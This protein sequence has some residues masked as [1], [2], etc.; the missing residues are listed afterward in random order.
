MGRSENQVFFNIQKLDKHHIDG[1]KETVQML[2]SIDTKKAVAQIQSKFMNKNSWKTRNKR[3]Y[4]PS[5]ELSMENLQH[6]L[7]LN[8]KY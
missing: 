4:S 3:K 1:L 6:A 8:M 7:Y 2:F 5:N